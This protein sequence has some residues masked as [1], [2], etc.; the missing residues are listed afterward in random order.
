LTPREGAHHGP[1]GKDHVRLDAGGP[2][3]PESRCRFDR[4]LKQRR[5]A[6]TRHATHHQHAALP[7]PRGVEEPTERRAFC[8]AI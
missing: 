3:D 8:V 2:R 5:L 1:F 6:N 7:S 4:V